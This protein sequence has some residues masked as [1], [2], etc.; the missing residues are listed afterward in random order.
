MS[1]DGSFIST[2]EMHA[3][4]ADDSI[5]VNK[6][7]AS[8]DTLDNEEQFENAPLSINEIDDGISMSINDVHPEKHILLIFD[9]LEEIFIFDKEVHPKKE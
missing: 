1:E 9:I 3:P 5:D 6:E 7:S 8:N 2:S 4:N